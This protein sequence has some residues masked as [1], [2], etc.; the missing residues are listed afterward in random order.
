MLHDFR[1]LEV[2]SLEVCYSLLTRTGSATVNV[3]MAAA[4]QGSVLYVSRQHSRQLLFE[5][6]DEVTRWVEALLKAQVMGTLQ[7]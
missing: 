7:P 6:A 2:D 3:P 1:C 5:V 4:L